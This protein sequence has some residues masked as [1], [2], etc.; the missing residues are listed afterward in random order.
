MPNALSQF[1]FQTNTVR[2]VAENGEIWF[3]AKDIASALEYS[4]SSTAAVL[5]QAVSMKRASTSSRCQ[6]WL[7]HCQPVTTTRWNRLDQNEQSG[8]LR[9]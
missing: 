1:N 3:V 6:S 5:F 4:V 9:G 2:T 7:L 8:E